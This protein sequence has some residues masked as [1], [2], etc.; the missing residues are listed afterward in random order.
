MNDSVQAYVN[1]LLPLYVT[2]LVVSILMVWLISYMV[3]SSL[4]MVSMQ[5]KGSRV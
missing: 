4:S 1:K 2:L 5:L 3:T